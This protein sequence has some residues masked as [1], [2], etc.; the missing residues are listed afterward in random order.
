MSSD[1]SSK[2]D[3]SGALSSLNVEDN[4]LA[5]N[6]EMHSNNIIDTISLCAA[7]GKEGDVDNV[8]SAPISPFCLLVHQSLQFVNAA[9]IPVIRK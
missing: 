6:E 3:L 7:C 5:S 2:A 4:E 1:S 8:P 9:I